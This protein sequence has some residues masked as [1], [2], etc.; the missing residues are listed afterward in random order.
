MNV[1]IN[2]I[3]N[4]GTTLINLIHHFKNE[5]GISEIYAL[6]NSEIQEWNEAD[7][8]FL[9]EKGVKIC[10]Q[11]GSG[12]Y[13]RVSDVIDSI[14][15][16]FDC[17]HSGLKNKSWYQSLKNLKGC[18]AQGSEK[19]FG[20]PYMVGINDQAIQSEKFAHVVSCNTHA[21]TALLKTFSEGDFS[22]I[23]EADFV[24]VRRSDDLVNHQKIVSANVVSRH[25]DDKMGTHHAI[26][27]HSLLDTIDVKI[28][29][30]SSD[31]NTPSQLMHT[32]R[33]NLK[34]KHPLYLK[35][36][37][38]LIGKSSFVSTTSKFDSNVIFELGRRYGFQ[39]RH[40][41]HCI[42]VDNNLLINSLEN[43]IKGWAFVPQEGNT[44]LSTISA[45]LLQT[46][47]ESH[48]FILKRMCHVLIS[49]K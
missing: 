47:N 34:F 48:A 17:T 41:E 15:Y 10:T 4:I 30:Q 2:G 38:T 27:T 35:E 1:L 3:G 49:P 11:E 46:G 16:I 40:F 36:I 26:D 45:F 5:M 6:K 13:L 43:R 14:D 20:V 19:D 32:V 24:V 22:N 31:I 28:P 44:L 39:G 42:L 21:I 33:F 7:L 25:M 12:N 8:A 37:R 18:S 29:L 9:K 23:L